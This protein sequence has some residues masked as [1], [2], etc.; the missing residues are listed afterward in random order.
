[1]PQVSGTSTQTSRRSRIGRVGFLK[2]AQKKSET[3]RLAR[4]IASLP[5]GEFPAWIEQ[6]LYQIGDQITRWSR[7]GDGVH[8][9]EALMAAETA[10]ALLTELKAR[11]D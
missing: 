8:L 1:M 6:C 7:N 5:V 3:T 9:D 11:E 4:R 10:V 2:K